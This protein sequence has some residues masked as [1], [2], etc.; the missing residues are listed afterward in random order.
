MSIPLDDRGA[1]LCRTTSHVQD[2]PAVFGLNH[3]AAISP[4]K[5]PPSLIIS[6]MTVPLNDTSATVPRTTFHVEALIAIHGIHGND[7]VV[8]IS[9]DELETPFLVSPIHKLPLLDGNPPICRT[10]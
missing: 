3:E 2:L 7:L 1:V 8:L 10:G 6:V 5:K 4:R 9:F